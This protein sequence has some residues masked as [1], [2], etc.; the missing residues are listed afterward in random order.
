[1]PGWRE[2]GNASAGSEDGTKVPTARNE[3]R[4]TTS[5]V[6]FHE[7]KNEAEDVALGVGWEKC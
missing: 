3:Q 5:D 2:L 6:T 7:R 1:M 4:C